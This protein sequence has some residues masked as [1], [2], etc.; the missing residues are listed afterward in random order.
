MRIGIDIDDTICN[1][2]DEIIGTVCKDFNFDNDEVVKS[3]KVY[4]DLIPLEG[5]NYYEYAKKYKYLLL[6]PKLKNNVKEVIDKL[7]TKNEIIFITSRND[8]CYDDAYKY[9]K[10]YLDK[11]NIYY[12]DIIVNAFNKGKIC[13]EKNID[14]FIDDSC[15]NCIDVNKY[16]I[17]T[18]LF[19]NYYNTNNNL[20]KVSDWNEILNIVEEE[21]NARE[22]V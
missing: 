1:S 18:L 3:K 17:K 12:D 8:Y 21:Y 20:K 4:N 9:S 5:E 22:I 15:D 13:K 11:N 14:I 19:L 7:S 6:N 10:K 2:W 16:G